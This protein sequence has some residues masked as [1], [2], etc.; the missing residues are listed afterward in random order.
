MDALLGNTCRADQ[1][2]PITRSEFERTDSEIVETIAAYKFIHLTNNWEYIRT[3][4][5][6]HNQDTYLEWM[7]FWVTIFARTQIKSSREVNS[8]VGEQNSSE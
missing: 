8:S 7:R 4:L 2:R 3:R 5:P 6:A 1:N